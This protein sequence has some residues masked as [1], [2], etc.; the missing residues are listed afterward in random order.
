MK[1]RTPLCVIVLAAGKGTRMKSSRA[2]V[3]HE[4]FYRP[5]LHHVLDSVAPLNPDTT[6]VIVG[7]QKEA[8]TAILDDYK[9]TCC[10]QREQNGTGHAVLSARSL[11]ADFQGTL[12]IINGDA[13]LLLTEHLEQMIEA[14]SSS[15]AALTIMT[16]AL[17]DPTNYG[18]VIS[19]SFGAVRAVV[20]EKDADD[21]QR[22]VKEINAGIYIGDAEIIF[23]A[24]DRVTTD[25][26]QGEMYLTDIVSIGVGDGQMVNKFEHPYPNHVLGVNS[27][28][29]M[30]RAQRELSARRNRELMAMGVTMYDPP[31]IS[32]G[33]DVTLGAGCRL[34]AAV[35]IV[36]RSRIGDNCTIEP[37]VYLDDAEIGDEVKI[38][39]NSVVINYRVEMATRLAPLTLLDGS[40]DKKNHSQE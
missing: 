8:V 3:L 21:R 31:T 20:E 2:K 27:K 17:N 4:V 28:V 25:N 6:I 1:K 32:V 34:G 9:V 5:M 37:G 40:A 24:L 11:L 36:G 10:E 15:G 29:E 35:T 13:P 14:H 39:A 22:A 12:M 16:T 26:A 30:A 18:R 7:H 23:G 19:D 33:A 38:G